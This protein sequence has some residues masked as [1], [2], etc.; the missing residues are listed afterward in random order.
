MK[1]KK[2]YGMLVD[3]DKCIGCH[4]CEIACKMAK[5]TPLGHWRSWVKEIQKGSFPNVSWVY[6]PV[7][8][9]QCENPICV[10]IC[11]VKASIKRE[12]DGIVVILSLI[13]I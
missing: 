2:R 8:C 4:A 12:E 9:N 3:V 11:P 6:M 5:G 10:T 1:S 7:F 13:H